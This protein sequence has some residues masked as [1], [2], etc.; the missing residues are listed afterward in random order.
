MKDFYICD[1]DTIKSFEADYK[2]AEAEW[3][4]LTPLEKGTILFPDMSTKS[5]TVEEQAALERMF[6]DDTQNRLI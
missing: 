1:Y 5:L 6:A 3:S 4:K 2:K